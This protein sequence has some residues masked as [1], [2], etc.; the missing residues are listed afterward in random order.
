MAEPGSDPGLED[1]ESL[2]SVAVGLS[3]PPQNISPT[4]LQGPWEWK[5]LCKLKDSGPDGSLLF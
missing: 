4:G 5:E 2:V 1:S 3:V